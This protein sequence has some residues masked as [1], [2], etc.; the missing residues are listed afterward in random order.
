MFWL[1]A[2]GTIQ[3]SGQRRLVQNEVVDERG[4]N[5][6]AF[7]VLV[8][9]ENNRDVQVDLVRNLGR[10]QWGVAITTGIVPGCDG[11]GLLTREHELGARP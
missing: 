5:R 9:Y 2:P 4:L 1:G 6:L 7:V 10:S 11:L 8:P 3:V